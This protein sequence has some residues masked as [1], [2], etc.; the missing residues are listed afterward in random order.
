MVWMGSNGHMIV[1]GIQVQKV[2]GGKSGQS[3]AMYGS[4][5]LSVLAALGAR[6]HYTGY[7]WSPLT[8]HRLH[9][10]PTHP[11]LAT[12]GAQSPYTGYTR[13]PLTLHWLHL[14]PTH[15]SLA[16]LGAGAHSPE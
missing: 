3:Q 13:T 9:L 6:L 10:E 7:T 8:L 14:E 4:T 2:K 1:D 16:T 12:L 5:T 11:T 15:P